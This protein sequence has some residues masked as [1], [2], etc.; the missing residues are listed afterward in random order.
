MP[1][2][3]S[4]SWRDLWSWPALVLVL[5]LALGPGQAWPMHWSEALVAGLWCYGAAVLA[6]GPS[7]HV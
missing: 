1:Y 3:D 6:F 7:T 5:V 2:D 4:S